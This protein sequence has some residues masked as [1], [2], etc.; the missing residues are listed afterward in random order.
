MPSHDSLVPDV[1]KWI[2]PSQQS[3]KVNSDTVVIN[4]KISIGVAVRDSK[5]DMMMVLESSFSLI[6]LVELVR[7][8]L[9]LKI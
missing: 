9:S 8:L 6:G 4:D 3:F 2:P 5:G 7:Q 1:V